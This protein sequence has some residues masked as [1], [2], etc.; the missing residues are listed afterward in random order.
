MHRNN[1]SS[2]LGDPSLQ[3]VHIDQTGAWIHVGNYGYSAVVEH[4]IAGGD[5]CDRRDDYFIARID[6]DGVYRRL[7][8]QRAVGQRG[9]ILCAGV[10]RQIPLKGFNPRS[11]RNP[12]GLQ[13]VQDFPDVVVRDPLVT[14]RDL[15]IGL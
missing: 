4:A 7:Q 6:S 12:V 15:P 8:S 13:N 1:G 2:P 11:L 14:V 5:K 10:V 9:H 3:V